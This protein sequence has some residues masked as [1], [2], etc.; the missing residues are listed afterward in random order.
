MTQHSLDD[1][2]G[3]EKRGYTCARVASKINKSHP[4]TERSVG[5]GATRLQFAA[6]QTIRKNTKQF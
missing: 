1:G 3:E 5:H 2:R 6:V 4:H